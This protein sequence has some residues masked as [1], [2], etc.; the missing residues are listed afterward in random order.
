MT[1]SLRLPTSMGDIEPYTLQ[2]EPIRRPPGN[3]AFNRVAYS[4]AHVVAHPLAA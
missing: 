4:A 2:G 3:A 1:T